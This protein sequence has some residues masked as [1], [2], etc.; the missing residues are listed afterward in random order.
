MEER[1][2]LRVVRGDATAE[3]VAA[4][5]AVIAAA[6]AAAPAPPETRKTSAWTNK[7]RLVR[8]PMRPG[9]GTWRASALPG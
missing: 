9:P 6:A 2:F 5:L 4:V 8:R 3:E 1:P 7:T